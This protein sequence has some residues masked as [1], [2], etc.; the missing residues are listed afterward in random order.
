M[1]LD[2]ET[3]DRLFELRDSRSRKGGWDNRRRNQ[4]APDG[5]RYCASCGELKEYNEFSKARR[6]VHPYCKPCDRIR[7]ISQQYGISAADYK[8]MLEVQNNKCALCGRGPNER[9]HK[10]NTL[11][12]DHNHETGKVRGL[13]CSS[14]NSRLGWYERYH[15]SVEL[16]L[17]LTEID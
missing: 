17:E 10:R 9:G 5:F 2:K 7:L 6:G 11:Q 14:C 13:L 15:K 4:A 16:Y 3:I 12:V 1:P 8:Q